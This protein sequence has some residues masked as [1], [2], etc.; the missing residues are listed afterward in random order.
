MPHDKQLPEQPYSESKAV[1]EQDMTE[2]AKSFGQ[3]SLTGSKPRL[4]FSIDSILGRNDE[5]A[6]LPAQ[7][8]RT[9]ANEE[10]RRTCESAA[11]VTEGCKSIAQLP[12]LS[13][14]RYSPPKLP[15]K[16]NSLTAILK[17]R[18]GLLDVCA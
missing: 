10:E 18:Y 13:Y 8:V 5:P 9:E 3:Q 15:S 4:A 6:L 12:W 7:H 16:Y 14:T 11:V 1:A 2:W 17:V